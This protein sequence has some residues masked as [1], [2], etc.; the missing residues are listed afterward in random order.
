MKA[1]INT[2]TQLSSKN[3]SPKIALPFFHSRSSSDAFLNLDPHAFTSRNELLTF[4]SR[5]L[6]RESSHTVQGLSRQGSFI[7]F[8]KDPQLPSAFKI[9][10]NS[11]SATEL[12]SVSPKQQERLDKINSVLSNINQASNIK[13]QSKLNRTKKKCEILEDEIKLISRIKYDEIKET[14][15]SRWKRARFRTVNSQDILTKK[16]FKELMVTWRRQMNT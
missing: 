16:E 9:N 1:S 11:C 8:L 10:Y 3:N 14:N 2:K 7:P 5:R 4:K 15:R 12:F 6:T 13:L